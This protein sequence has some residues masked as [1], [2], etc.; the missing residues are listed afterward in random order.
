M[1]RFIHVLYVD[2]DMVDLLMDYHWATETLAHSA[3]SILNGNNQCSAT[4]Q[5]GFSHWV[6]YGEHSSGAGLGFMVQLGRSKV[7]LGFLIMNDNNTPYN[8]W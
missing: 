4:D 7:L 2:C 5:T 8:N 3:K 1:F 6:R